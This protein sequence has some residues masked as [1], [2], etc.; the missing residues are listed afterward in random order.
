MFAASAL[1][2]RMN[3]CYAA[4]AAFNSLSP[5]PHTLT[6]TCSKSVCKS[7]SIRKHFFSFSLKMFKTG[8]KPTRW[9]QNVENWRQANQM[10]PVQTSFLIHFMFN[11]K[12]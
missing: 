6:H 10:A 5:P 4:A 1:V 9:L 7:F 8:D 2:F 3:E 11:H 12:H